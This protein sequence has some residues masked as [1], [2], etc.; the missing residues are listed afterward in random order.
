MDRAHGESG[1]RGAGAGGVTPDHPYYDRLLDWNYG[2]EDFRRWKANIRGV[3]LGDQ[4]PAHWEEEV[5]RRGKT[6]P[7]P[8]DYAGTAPLCEPEAR[9]LYEHTLDISP[10]RAVSLHSQGKEI[11]WNY[12]DYEPPETE[13]WARILGK[14]AGYR[15]VKLQG[16]DA[17]YKDWFIQH[18]RRPGFT[19]E[20]GFG[21]NPL[22]LEDFEDLCVE[23]GSIAAAFMS[24]K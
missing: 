11:Y 8:Q 3:D 2:R 16:S 23:A 17:G 24:L 13:D 19:V 14:A 5:E 12:R 22:P 21:V 6:G 1:R 7:C 9:A 18:Y 4:F 10:V 20:I 15:P